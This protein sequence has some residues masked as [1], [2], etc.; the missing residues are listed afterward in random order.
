MVAEF[1]E[2]RNLQQ[3]AELTRG[4]PVEDAVDYVMQA[5]RGLE[6]AHAQGV[7]HRDVKP[8]NLLLEEDRRLVKITDF[9]LARIL[10]DSGPQSST[11]F[12]TR[13][14]ETFGTP[15][16]LSPE[17]ANDTR[18]ADGRSDV[19]SLGCTFFTLVAGRLMYDVRGVVLMLLAHEREPIPPLEA[20]QGEVPPRLN[21]VFRKMVAK[22]PEQR[23][24]SMEEVAEA[25]RD[26]GWPCRR[27]WWSARNSRPTRSISVKRPPR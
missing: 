12:A 23:F 13:E 1:I 9:G 19:Y 5:A 15:A 7:I 16:F 2:G 24:Q 18:S 14:G 21:A 17:Q 4:I 22:R 26:R 27:G 3:I 20:N 6:Y 8:A 11:R 25:L 10:G